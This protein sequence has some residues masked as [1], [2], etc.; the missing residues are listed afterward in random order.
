MCP[1]FIPMFFLIYGYFHGY[2]L[3]IFNQELCNGEMSNKNVAHGT[4]GCGPSNI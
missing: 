3:A 4:N 2:C 1:D